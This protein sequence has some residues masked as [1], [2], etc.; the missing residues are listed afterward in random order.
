MG[1]RDRLKNRV[2][3][4]GVKDSE[5]KP[6]KPASSTTAPKEETIQREPKPAVVQDSKPKTQDPKP[7]PSDT[8]D[9]EVDEALSPLDGLESGQDE[10]PRP[11]G[12]TL[13]AIDGGLSVASQDDHSSPPT[14][15][16]EDDAEDVVGSGDEP[17]GEAPEE[18]ADEQADIDPADAPPLELLEDDPEELPA[19]QPDSAQEAETDSGVELDSDN[20]DVDEVEPETEDDAA[21]ELTEDDDGTKEDESVDADQEYDESEDEEEVDESDPS[22]AGT[23]RLGPEPALEL[24]LDLDLEED[25]AETLDTELETHDPEPETEDT[26]EPDGFLEKAVD[27]V[28][29]HPMEFGAMAG[30][31]VIAAVAAYQGSSLWPLAIVPTLVVAAASLLIKENSNN[32]GETSD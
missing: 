9:G 32:R 1:I 7:V 5:L 28:T 4:A 25:S 19:D 24:D 13:S 23:V 15:L 14:D 6:R 30:S 26:T 3:S 10:P 11:T 29:D 21:P 2:R 27:Y 17:S 31:G 20:W 18:V 8:T 12:P 22:E 16:L